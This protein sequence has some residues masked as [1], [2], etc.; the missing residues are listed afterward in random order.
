[1]SAASPPQWTETKR[2][3]VVWLPE[4]AREGQTIRGILFERCVIMGPAVVGI[5]GDVLMDS[6]TFV[7]ATEDVLWE[8]EALRPYKWIGAIGVAGCAFVHCHFHRIGILA[9]PRV[10]DVFRLKMAEGEGE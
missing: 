1:M 5:V 9:N 8:Y 10:Q 3:E 7:E 4:L 2:D 6:P